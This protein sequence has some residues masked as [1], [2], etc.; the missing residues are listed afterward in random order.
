MQVWELIAKL[1]KC[2]ADADVWGANDGQCS[3]KIREVNTE[4]A[5][6]EDGAVYL[7]FDASE[8]VED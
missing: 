3:A 6:G 5:G 4:E 2:R 7:Y 1:S 8:P